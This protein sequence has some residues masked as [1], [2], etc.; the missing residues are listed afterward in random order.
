MGRPRF[1][2]VWRERFEE[3]GK[4]FDDDAAIAGWSRTGL[5][6]RLQ[7]FRELWR[8]PRA[9]SFWLDAGCGAG[10]YSRMLMDQ[11][12][13]VVGLDY[14]VASLRK[15]RS[16]CRGEGCWIAADVT[17]LPIRE[18]SADGVLCFGVMQT[19]E[20]PE[21]ALR[22]LTAVLRPGGH[23]WVDG[24]NRWCLPHLLG[25]LKRALRGEPKHLRYDTPRDL[26]A[27]LRSAGADRV[28]LHWLPLLPGRLQRARGLLEHPVARWLF[29][30]LPGVGLLLSHSFILVARR[31]ADAP[32]RL[33]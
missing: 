10:T 23:L 13:V 6:A 21:P 7:R 16:H 19:L 29:H 28:S 33:R 30:H 14:A 27:S 5:D 24:L 25:N 17:R 2:D 22:E 12:A 26:S 31:G 1:E 32:G 18:G 8:E 4:R 11:G 3:R 20:A 9:G 15:A